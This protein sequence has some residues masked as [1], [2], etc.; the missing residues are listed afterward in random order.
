MSTDASGRRRVRAS[1]AEREQYA[2]ILRAAMTEGRLNLE[3]G[4]ERLTKAY[5][6]TYRDELDPLTADLPDG[7][8]RALFETPEFRAAFRRGA[9][10]RAL[11]IAAVAA[12]LLGLTVLTGGHFLWLL[13]PLWFFAFAPWRR[14]WFGG[15]HGGWHGGCGGSRRHPTA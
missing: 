12:V 2:Q 3:E 14:R 4:E 6:A 5:A 15:W 11:A 8:R 1:D 13:I 9:R 7:G 10:N